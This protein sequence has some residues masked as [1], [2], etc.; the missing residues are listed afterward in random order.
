MKNIIQPCR[1]LMIDHPFGSSICKRFIMTNTFG[2]RIGVKASFVDAR[3]FHA[4]SIQLKEDF[5][6][7]LGVS[8]SS[9]KAEIKKKYFELAKKYHPGL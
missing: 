9:S 3:H 2:Y 1:K 7:T 8:K 5:Y 4:S 6:K